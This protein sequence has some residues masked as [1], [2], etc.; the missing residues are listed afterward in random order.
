MTRLL[1][2]CSFALT[3][4]GA[5]LSGIWNGQT[6]DRNGDA[7]DVSFRFIQKGDALTGKMYS[8]NES[9]AISEAKVSGDQ[10]TFFVITEL[11]GQVSKVAYT[12][13]LVADSAGKVDEIQLTRQRVGGN[14]FGGNAKGQNQRQSVK[15]KRVA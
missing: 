7:Q 6:V 13:T 5:D 12:G 9:I 15:L 4:S 8:D 2:L 3:L 11:N 14:A 10:I 1:V